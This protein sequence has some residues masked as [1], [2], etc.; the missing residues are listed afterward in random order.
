MAGK[1]YTA[2][3]VANI[4]MVDSTNSTND[5]MKDMEDSKVI[6]AIRDRLR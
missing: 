5:E 3:E 1:R 2:E 4:I 6:F